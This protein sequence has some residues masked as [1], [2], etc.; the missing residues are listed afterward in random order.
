[1]AVKTATNE[2]ECEKQG[3]SL[4]SSSLLPC[5]SLEGEAQR[6]ESATGKKAANH[7]DKTKREK[8]GL[9][10]SCEKGSNSSTGRQPDSWHHSEDDSE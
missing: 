10:C 6:N 1:M 5:L 9:P 3:L 7:C 8:Q 4:C 2:T